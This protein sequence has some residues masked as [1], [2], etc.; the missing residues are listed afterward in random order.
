MIDK[1]WICLNILIY[2]IY[3]GF[4]H[5]VFKVE[6]NVKKLFYMYIPFFIIGLIAKN[7]IEIWR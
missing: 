4:T 2:F 5:A 1:T 3:I 6:W 7:T